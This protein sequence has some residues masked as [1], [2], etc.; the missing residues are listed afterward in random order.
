MNCTLQ[1][2]WR[3]SNQSVSDDPGA[4]HILRIRVSVLADK[5]RARVIDGKLSLGRVAYPFS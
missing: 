5:M 1:Q 2:S 4:I 3:H